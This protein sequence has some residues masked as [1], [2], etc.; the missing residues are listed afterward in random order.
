MKNYM[1][2]AIEKLRSKEIT[3]EIYGEPIRGTKPTT[4]VVRLSDA[5]EVLQDLEVA[6]L[7]YIDQ[8]AVEESKNPY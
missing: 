1:T 6:I 5:E 2:E 3:G 4:G 7:N 8:K